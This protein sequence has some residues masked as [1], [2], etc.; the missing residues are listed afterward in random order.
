MKRPRAE[1]LQTIVAQGRLDRAVAIL[2]RLDPAVAADTL[3]SMP[4]EEQ[5]VL[6]RR[7]PIEFAAILAP[8][9]P[10]YHT[11]VL[12]HTLAIDH[13]NAVIERMN[14]IER[15]MFID[16]LPEEAWQQITSELSEEQSVASHEDE[17]S[18]SLVKTRIDRAAASVPPI[19]EARG[20][21]KW[22]QRPGGGQ[23]Q[24]IAPTSLSVDV[25]QDARNPADYT[26]RL[27]S[28]PDGPEKRGILVRRTK[29]RPPASMS[30][31]DHCAPVRLCSR[32]CRLIEPVA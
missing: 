25:Y 4:F 18:T 26:N 11:F 6:F 1:E 7:V 2:Q 28:A 30:H 14:P 31:Q 16:E 32:L 27:R 12:L 24:V 3:M 22:F 15:S 17:R 9:F 20:I 21:E 13:M 10:Y 29:G 23:I 19:I 8:I 5:K